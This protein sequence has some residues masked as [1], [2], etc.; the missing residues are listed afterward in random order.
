M[1]KLSL[2]IATLLVSAAPA[3]SQQWEILKAPTN[4]GRTCRITANREEMQCDVVLFI[5]DAKRARIQFNNDDSGRM[6]IFE[7][8]LLGGT[9]THQSMAV[10]AI[11]LGTVARRA[12]KRIIDKAVG[13][14]S[15]VDKTVECHAQTSGGGLFKGFVFR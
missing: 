8:K 9:H 13:I 1:T 3:A 4:D 2:I 10:D 15:F 11:T 7:V 6:V 14:C 5:A 12:D